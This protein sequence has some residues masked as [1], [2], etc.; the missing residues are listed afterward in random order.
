MVFGE[1]LLQLQQQYIAMLPVP[2]LHIS[3]LL[4]VA[5]KIKQLT[6]QFVNYAQ[7]NDII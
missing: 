1:L 6:S 7:L 2:R 3:L 4:Q 5:A